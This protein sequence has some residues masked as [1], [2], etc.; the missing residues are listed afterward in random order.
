MLSFWPSIVLLSIVQGVLVALPGP[1]RDP[2]LARLRSGRWAVIPPL[3][4]VGFVFV[5]RA[6]ENASADGLTYLALVCVPV[7]AALALGV[8][9]RG[10]RGRAALLVIPLFALAWADRGDLPGQAAALALTGLSCVSLGVLL[11]AVTPPRWLGWGIV[12]MALADAALVTADLL[13][14]PN[15][16]LNAAHPAAGLP[17]LQSA[18]LGSAVMGYGDLFIAA[19]LGAL[20]AS[21]FGLAE[22][23]RGAVLVAVLA[24]LF[25]LL[26]LTV[27]E[28]PA[29]VPVATALV[30]IVLRRRRRGLEGLPEARPAP[31]LA[32][33]RAD[34]VRGPL[35]P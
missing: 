6:A 20:L 14:R 30:L 31:R 1:L 27:E 16:A 33:A 21:E 32:A 7:L 5:T 11:A 13:Q 4:V 28:L 23:L 10:A 8:L 15:N 26:F 12:L 3:S 34:P 35:A 22:Q 2:R 9:G 25:D 18:V 24:L 29:T 17:R 19:A